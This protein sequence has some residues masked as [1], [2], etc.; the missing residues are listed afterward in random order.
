MLRPCRDCND[1]TAFDIA[2]RILGV[3]VSSK[4]VEEGIKLM[5]AI[6]LDRYHAKREIVYTCRHGNHQ[7]INTGDG[8]SVPTIMRNVMIHLERGESIAALK[9]VEDQSP[10]VLFTRD[11]ITEKY[12]R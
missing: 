2:K 12:F 7:I 11:S 10:E 5:T 4:K 8:V 9:L 1:E 3:S 6:V